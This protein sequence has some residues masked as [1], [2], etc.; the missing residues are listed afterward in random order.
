MVGPS[1]AHS[2]QEV[3]I[4]HH[5]DDPDLQTEFDALSNNEDRLDYIEA[6]EALGHIEEQGT[7]SF[8]EMK[9]RLSVE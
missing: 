4:E 5:F 8:E 1:H 6:M 7:I 2:T 3:P 9:A